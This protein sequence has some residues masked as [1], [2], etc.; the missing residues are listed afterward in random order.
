M[1]LYTIEVPGVVIYGLEVTSVGVPSKQTHAP[2]CGDAPS[3]YRQLELDIL[4]FTSAVLKLLKSSHRSLQTWY[5]TAV[6]AA[7]KFPSTL[8]S[9]PLWPPRRTWTLAARP[10]HAPLSIPARP[11]PKFSES[12]RRSVDD[13]AGRVRLPFFLDSGSTAVVGMRVPPPFR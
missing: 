7:M 9:S 12:R 4:G 11:P 5:D 2:N 8:L 10:P 1:S 6:P 13:G 3:R